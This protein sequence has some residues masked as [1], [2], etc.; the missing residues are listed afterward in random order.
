MATEEEIWKAMNAG[1]A[2]LA[3]IRL[4]YAKGPA[5]IFTASAFSKRG[6]PK[7]LIERADDYINELGGCPGRDRDTPADESGREP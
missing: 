2:A 5:V 7:S 3:E 4:Y 6:V 1:K